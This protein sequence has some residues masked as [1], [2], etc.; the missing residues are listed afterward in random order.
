M[1]RTPVTSKMIRSV[2]YDEIAKVLE[3]E[4]QP[5]VKKDKTV[6]PGAIWQYEGVPQGRYKR[7]LAAESIGKYFITFIRA[8]YVGNKVERD[9]ESSVPT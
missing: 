8:N 1:E 6:V 4:F 2:G 3:V 5:R 7:M 9:Q